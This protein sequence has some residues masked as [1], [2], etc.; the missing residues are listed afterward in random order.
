MGDKVDLFGEIRWWAHAPT[1]KN[2]KKNHHALVDT[3]VSADTGD[4]V[5]AQHLKD[6][7]CVRPKSNLFNAGADTGRVT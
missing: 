6:T 3:A 7:G 4:R 2:F 1:V 5:S